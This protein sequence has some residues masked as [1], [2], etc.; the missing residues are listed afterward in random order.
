MLRAL[1][2]C[3]ENRIPGRRVGVFSM[4]IKSMYPSLELDT[5]VYL[6]GKMIEESELLIDGID[7][8]EVGKYLVVMYGE[9]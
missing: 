7:W 4:D 8:E 5:V 2:D 6:V 9:I 3:S 1:R